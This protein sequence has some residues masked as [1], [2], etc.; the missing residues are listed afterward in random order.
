[1]VVRSF[2]ALFKVSTI[3]YLEIIDDGKKESNQIKRMTINIK[4]ITPSE[5]HFDLNEND[6]A[7]A[8]WVKKSVCGFW[9]TFLK[10]YSKEKD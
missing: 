2:S 10:D 4:W 7:L 9:E 8:L 6:D 1:M 3:H 5:W